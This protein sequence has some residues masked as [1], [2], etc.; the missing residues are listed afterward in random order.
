VCAW[1][2]VDLDA[3]EIG[4]LNDVYMGLPMKSY[5]RTRGWNDEELDAGEERLRS[6]G[7]LDGDALSDDGRD[8]R[9][10][11]ERA[12]DRQMGTA[13]EV[14]GDDLGAVVGLLKPWGE[15]MREAGGYIA[16]PV[17]LWPNRDD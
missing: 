16:G 17:D 3:V 14:L 6:R 1:A 12:T 2:S 13:L 15:K 10:G 7:W 9:E 4:L 8:A 5:V 11:I